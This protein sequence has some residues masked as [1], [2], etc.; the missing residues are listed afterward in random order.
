MTNNGS[1]S[2]E[3]SKVLTRRELSQQINVAVDTLSRWHCSGRGP[4]GV[5]EGRVVRYAQAEVDA[6]LRGE[7][8]DR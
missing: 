6:W 3:P 4:R 2:N 1:N 8:G 5:K 7:R